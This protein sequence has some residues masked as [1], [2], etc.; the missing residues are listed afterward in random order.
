MQFKGLNQEKGVAGLNVFLSIIAML[1]MIGIIVMIFALAGA[2]LSEQVEFDTGA[3]IGN[4]TTDDVVNETGTYINGTSTLSNCV[5][6]VTNASNLSNAW[7]HPGNYSVTNCVIKFAGADD[8]YNNTKWV[9]NGTYT[10][11]A[12]G[13]ASVAIDNTVTALADVPDWFPT[14]IVLGAMVV[15]ILLVVIII[16]S[17]KGAGITEGA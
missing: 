4:G 9:L 15:L 7:I 12:K 16:N 17:I 1:F 11:T 14:I 2:K 10:F 6:T 3:G 8:S 5:G 13:T